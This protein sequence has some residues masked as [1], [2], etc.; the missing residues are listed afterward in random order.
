MSKKRFTFLAVLLIA[1]LLIA[2]CGGGDTEMA[3]EPAAPAQEEQA[4]EEK[5]EMAAE[6][7]EETEEAPAA[8]E[9]AAAMS[10]RTGAWVDEVIAVEEPSAAAAVTRMDLAEL[11]AYAFS[12]SDA[13][14]YATVQGMD[15]LTYANSFGVYSELTFNPAGPVFDGTG[16]LNPFAVPRIREAMNYLVDRDFISQEIYGGLASPRYMAITNAF[17]DYAR[18]VDI[19]RQIELEYAHNPDKAAEIINEEMEALGAELVD[20]VWN[21]EEEPVEVIFLIR[22]EDER[23]EIGD[24]VATMLEDLGFSVVR[25]YKTASEASPI[26]IG[27]DPNEGKFHIYTGG[28]ITTVISRDQAGNFDFFYTNRGLPFP[29]WQA[30]TPSEEFDAMSEKL[31]LRD[32]TSMEERR[33]L[34]ADVLALSMQDSV[35]VWL[36]NRLGFTAYR[37]DV[38]VSTDLA[39]GLNGSRLWPYTLRRTGEEGGT[40]TI[41]MPSMLPEPW[42]PVAGTNWIYDTMLIRATADVGAMPDPFT[43]LQWPQRFDRAEVTVK[44]GLPVGS[45]HDW[46]DLTFAE[47][48]DVPEDAWLD[49]DAVEQRFITVGDL[50]PDGLTANVKSVV[51]YPG[52]LSE[53]TWHDGSPLSLADV[54]LSMITTFDLAKEES[55][56]YDEAQVPSLNNFQSHFRG[57]RIAQTSPLVIEYYSDQYTL[58]AEL[59]V[60]NFFPG[61]PWHTMAVGL[62]AEAAGDLAFSS[63]KADANEVEWMSYI[64]GPSIEILEG[65]LESG[66]ADGHI[67]Y[68]S[69]L[70][71]Y[72]SADEADARWAN[73]SAWY[74]DKGHFWVGNGPFYLEEAFPTE[75]TVQLLRVE[76]FPDASS[77]WEGFDT[78]MIAEVSVDGP[79]RVASGD[80]ATFEVMIDFGGDAYAID[81]IDE[82][83]YLVFDALGDLA[84]T[85]TAEAVEDGLWQITLSAEETAG[86]E[87]GANK[88][89]VAVAPLRVS[90]PTFSSLEFVTTN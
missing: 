14:V 51:H 63:D 39:G 62:L 31:D 60:A 21:Y 11:D 52:D 9:E 44:E 88:L 23:K 7:K 78:P 3:E 61:T 15:S 48:I 68:V 24:Y 1:A 37:G 43:G 55:A 65:H 57:Y 71:D 34:F 86:L 41:A 26:W 38:S 10:E 53:L 56:V 30:Y 82:V 17:P 45:T 84:L 18:L 66:A 80:E 28:W 27:T 2:A 12:I 64:A 85:G 22:T 49:W 90:I 76:S 73:L 35:R 32:F 83:K 67:P 6:E 79:A 47:Q 29:L 75:K 8:E 77:K 5:E 33:E 42:N 19:V 72:I 70:G 4:A 59:N 54:V 74:E 58:D 50:H 16:K 36:V 25:D 20:G 46:V 40:L 81:D 87:S 69:T 89:E 13:E